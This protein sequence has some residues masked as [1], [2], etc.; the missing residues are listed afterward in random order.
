MTQHTTQ[1]NFYFV[2][3][4]LNF[5]SVND[6]TF[7]WDIHPVMLRTNKE[8]ITVLEHIMDMEMMITYKD[9][10]NLIKFNYFNVILI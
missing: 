2:R 8:F 3:N 7:L 10:T 1:P 9:P 5:E 4:K 6:D